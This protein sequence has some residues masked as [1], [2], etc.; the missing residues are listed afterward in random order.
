[1]S[2]NYKLWSFSTSSFLQLPVPY[3]L[4]P[5]NLLVPLV[6]YV[7][8]VVSPQGKNHGNLVGNTQLVSTLQFNLILFTEE[9]RICFGF[10]VDAGCLC[11]KHV[12]MVTIKWAFRCSQPK[13]NF[14][15]L[16]NDITLLYVLTLSLWD[17]REEDVL[18]PDW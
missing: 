16:K 2:E 3:I 8:F 10:L 7:H 1:M 9:T 13:K 5:S 15:A 4:S 12:L 11:D 6:Q 18:W 14:Q 17:W